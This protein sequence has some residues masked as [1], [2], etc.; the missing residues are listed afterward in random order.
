MYESFSAPHME[1]L[2]IKVVSGFWECS[3]ITLRANQILHVTWRQM[4]HEQMTNLMKHQAIHRLQVSL[5][6]TIFRLNLNK[7]E[8][9][10][11]WARTETEF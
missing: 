2:R 3:S 5:G 11:N 10:N 8:K 6:H 4:Q 1:N 9:K 7:P